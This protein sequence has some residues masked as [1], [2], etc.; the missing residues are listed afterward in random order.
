MPETEAAIRI[1]AVGGDEA[2]AA[3]NKPKQAMENIGGE[4]NKLVEKFSHRFSHIG[5]S[6][7]ATDA[8]RASG[9]AGET[10][11]IISTMNMGITSM[12]AAFGASLTNITLVITALV[13]IYGIMEKVKAK[14]AEHLKELEKVNKETKDQIKNT[15]E[16]IKSISDYTTAI[17]FVP[18][19]LARW[20]DAE[21]ALR[22]VQI[23][24]QIEGDKAMVS[25]I[26]LVMNASREKMAQ[27]KD[28]IQA[29]E[30]MIK[31]LKATG[32]D[33][34]VIVAQKAKLNELTGEYKKLG[35]AQ[36]EN[37]AKLEGMFVEIKRLNQGITQSLADETKATQQA[38][39]DW[40][41]SIQDEAD[42]E[43]AR[44]QHWAELHA[45]E[46][47]E[48]NKSVQ[49]ESDQETKRYQNW[50]EIHEKQVKKNGE[51]M[52]KMYK[53]ISAGVDRTFKTFGDA[54]A[55]MLVKG[56]KFTLSFKKLFEDMA[57]AIISEIIQMEIRWLAFQA[58]T[59]GAG[60]LAGGGAG[61]IFGFAEGGSVMVNKPTLFLAGEAGQPELATFTPLSKMGA[62]SSAGAASSG[63]SGVQIG[64]INT[65]VYGVTDPDAIADK[66]GLKIAERIRGQGE[67]NFTRSS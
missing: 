34:S 46:M 2:A 52:D 3:L 35:D 14:H 25:S 8:L 21:D 45:K 59:G 7:F 37:K 63:S 20:R 67:I 28:E 48:K 9:V 51:F 26:T 18:P 15:D 16:I 10:N 54:T 6:L 56:E 32:V 40:I 33:A 38:S 65:N 1:S 17:G 55:A 60:G 41:K 36:V 50:A 12:G 5:L 61:K 64:S 44:Y 58:V 22:K 27:L 39:K 43:T 42:A 53:G 31:E 47:E 66:V 23:Q 57:Q 29:T 49:T 11:K 4:H 30:K 19:E 13:A 62:G 24:R